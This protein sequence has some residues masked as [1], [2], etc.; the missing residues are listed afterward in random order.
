MDVTGA[1]L[2]EAFELSVS[3][4]PVENGGFLHV[5][6]AKV[7]FDSSKPAGERSCKYF[8]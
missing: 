5:S 1:E 4:Y 7:E 3:K 6:G 8:I 2:K